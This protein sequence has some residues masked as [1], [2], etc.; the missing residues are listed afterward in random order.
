M[1]AATSAPVGMPKRDLE[2]M[3]RQEDKKPRSNETAQRPVMKRDANVDSASN[4]AEQVR[5]QGVGC[6]ACPPGSRWADTVEM[7]MC[8]HAVVVRRH[9]GS[10][11]EWRLRE[12]V[13]SVWRRAHVSKLE[14]SQ[15]VVRSSPGAPRPPHSGLCRPPQLALPTTSLV[16]VTIPPHRTDTIR[17]RTE[18][19]SHR[20]MFVG[21]SG[22]GGALKRAG[23]KSL[24]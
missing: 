9:F 20:E 1:L 3:S 13:R 21:G 7:D 15:R 17:K 4:E 16:N 6:D 10:R 5:L 23:G 11:P 8:E 22:G 14:A 18:Q 2:D 12:T 19:G 24:V